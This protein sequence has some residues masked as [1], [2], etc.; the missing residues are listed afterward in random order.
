M[1]NEEVMKVVQLR[2]HVLEF[3]NSLEEPHIATSMMTTKDSAVLCEQ[4]IS[5]L[6]ELLREYVTFE[7]RGPSS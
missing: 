2:Q 4:V 5:S 3:Y 6:D 7:K 1:K